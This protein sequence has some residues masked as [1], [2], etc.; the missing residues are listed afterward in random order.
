MLQQRDGRRLGMHQRNLCAPVQDRERVLQRLQRLFLWD[1]VLSVTEAFITNVSHFYS[2]QQEAILRD[3]FFK[4]L[5]N[6]NSTTHFWPKYTFSQNKHSSCRVR[7]HIYKVRIL[8]AP[9][10]NFWKLLWVAGEQLS[11]WPATWGSGGM[12]AFPE[13]VYWSLNHFP[14]LC[15]SPRLGKESQGIYGCYRLQHGWIYKIWL[16]LTTSYYWKCIILLG[17]WSHEGH[18]AAEH[19]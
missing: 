1:F 18:R 8:T 15:T 9:L 17:M 7:Y 3:S 16:L 19:L 2:E 4:F 14:F 11:S 6:G 12:D 10:E 5:P 13:D